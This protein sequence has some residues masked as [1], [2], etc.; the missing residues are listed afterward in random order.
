MA[1]AELGNRGF[2]KPLDYDMCAAILDGKSKKKKK[3]KV[4]LPKFFLLARALVAAPC[5][6]LLRQSTLTGTDGAN[7]D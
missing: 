7:S 5:Q 1:V 2:H 6:R 3:K 4:I